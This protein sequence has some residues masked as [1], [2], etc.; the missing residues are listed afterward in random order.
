MNSVQTFDV[1]M[2]TRIMFGAGRT[3]EVGKEA[4]KF[5]K[6]AMI[7]TYRDIH[8]LEETIERVAGYLKTA[9]LS[10]AKY[11]EVEPDPSV[12]TINRGAEM[13][14]AE[15]AEVMIG[16]AAEAPSTRPRLSL[17]WW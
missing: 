11:T 13:A 9:G 2:P 3:S 15:K 4:A 7:V 6:R 14:R 1:N 8:G 5:G 10:A 17:L 16:W 12:E